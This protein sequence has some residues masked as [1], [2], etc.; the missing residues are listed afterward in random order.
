MSKKINLRIRHLNLIGILGILAFLI[1][2]PHF[3]SGY[4]VSFL[5]IVLM[6][7][8]IAESWNIFGGFTGYFS[9][10][11]GAFFGVGAYVLALA[12]VKGGWPYF[13][14]IL[15]AAVGALLVALLIGLIL[16]TKRMSTSY[17]AL[18][19]LGLNEI[20]RTIVT[21]NEFLG[22]AYG[23]TLPPLPGLS[24]PYYILLSVA[25]G[26]VA[27]T[28]ILDK[29]TTG[30]VLK[31]ISQDEEVADTIG[32][33]TARYKLGIFVFSAIPIGIAG[34]V[35]ASFWSYV[36]PDMAFY[37]ILCFEMPIIA[38]L[39]GMGTVFGPVIAAIFV[40]GLKE[41]LSTTMPYFHL[42]LFGAL[43]TAVIVISP[44]GLSEVV[45]KVFPRT[46]GAR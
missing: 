7:I 44:K 1:L 9:L 18:I 10:G 42:I 19:T 30:W 20:L 37:L 28:Y 40:S 33:N 8:I 15:L 2:L 41:V 38:I 32:I 22:E 12:L 5:I 25:V 6:Y 34:A 24:T 29:S 39:G 21:N 36:N 16:L 46:L 14:G 43:V 45:K 23:I 17:F 3:F 26:V 31:A 27:A 4:V 35:M 11:H 13:Y